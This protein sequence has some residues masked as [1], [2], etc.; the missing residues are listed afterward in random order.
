MTK[1][2]GYGY[3]MYMSSATSQIKQRKQMSLSEKNEFNFQLTKNKQFIYTGTYKL[4]M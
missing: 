3:H 2:A 1:A 4:E